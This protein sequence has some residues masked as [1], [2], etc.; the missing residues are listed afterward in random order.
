M[1]VLLLKAGKRTDFLC[2]PL[3][4]RLMFAR[5]LVPILV[6]VGPPSFRRWILS[7]VPSGPVRE[8]TDVVN[9][10]ESSTKGILD[11]KKRA[12]DQGDAKVHAQVGK[13]KDILSVL[14]KFDR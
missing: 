9:Q 13:G 6:K 7:L 11:D 4:F 12:L 3:L 10:I 5:L 2:R 1:V 14:R 8:L